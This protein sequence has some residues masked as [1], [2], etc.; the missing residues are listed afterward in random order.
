LTRERAIDVE[1]RVL[2][3]ME[4]LVDGRSVELTAPRPRALLAALLLRSGRVVPTDDLMDALWGDE[5][6][7]SAASVLR[8]YVSRV[9]RALGDGRI[10]T[11]PPGYL[12]LVGEGELDADRFEQL[13]ADGRRALAQENPR[14]ARSLCARALELWRGDALSG[15]A[16]EGYVAREAARLD[17][18]RLACLEC[19]LEADLRLGRHQ[20]VLAELE[21]LVALHPLR[22]NLRGQL[23]LALYRSGRQ[24]DALAAYRDGRT[25][26][27]DELGLEPGRDLRELERRMLEQDPTLD[28]APGSRRRP[29]GLPAPPTRTIG[30]D[31]ELAAIVERLLDPRTRLLTLLGPG[32]IGKTRLAVEAARRLDDEL[33]DGAVLVDLAPVAEPAHLLPAIGR[34]LGLREDGT[35]WPELLASHLAGLELLLVLDNLEHLVDATAPLGELLAVVPRLTILATS[36]RVLRLAA[37][38]ILEVEPLDGPASLELLAERVVAAA[39][40]TAPEKAWLDAI[41]SR[42]EGL[43]LAIELA[44]PWFRTLP[45]DALLSLLDSRLHLLA[46]GARDQ[47]LRQRTMRSALDWSYELLEPAPQRLLGR[48]SIFSGG[49]TSEAAL[50]MGEGSTVEHLAALVDASFVRPGRGRYEMLDVVREYA[51]ELPSADDDGRDLHA[52]HYLLLAERAEAHLT[53]AEQGA[54]LATLETEHDNLRAASDWA[55]RSGNSRVELG[56]AAALGRFWYV[57]GYLSEGLERILRANDAASPAEP[58]LRA[59]ALRAASALALL[60]GDYPLA[61]EL[62]DRALELYRQ[63][64]DAAGVAR[65]LSNLGAILH[66]QNR[67]DEAAQT[68]DACIE[69]C[70]SLGDERLTAMARNNRG[71]VALSQGDLEV[72]AEQFARSLDLLR[73]VDDVANVARALYNLGAVALEQQHAGDAAALLLEALELSQG[74][75]DD[76]DTA[77]CLIGLAAL[78]ETGG[79]ELDG[80]RLLGLAAMLVDRLGATMKPFERGLYDRTHDR[81]VTTLGAAELDT[82]RTEG[83]RLGQDE[84]IELARTVARLDW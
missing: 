66:A 57:R 20:A 46:G 15:L 18:L 36:R 71:D 33:A 32:G 23:M 80:A 14:L 58:Q 76:E 69:A 73:A 44:A 83:A 35:P 16:V 70:K 9:R 4:V 26:M 64:G 75:A 63:S 51:A 7:A 17:E 41:S 45:P 52:R 2:G 72:A 60:Q 1:F 8:M 22:E 42:L 47:P 11:R 19:R 3:P 37:E 59:K 28:E 40:R 21:Q 67:L 49:F 6:P 74:I 78:A 5:V 30:R 68:L 65:C 56:L 77:W 43:P 81:L 79:R 27:V 84:A 38:E 31:R 24:A 13:L 25:A 50:V 53:G 55:A 39:A 12:L 10:V 82:A 34:G 62:A 61:H 29:G 48:L 54:W